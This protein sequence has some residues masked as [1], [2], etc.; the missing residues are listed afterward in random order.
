MICMQQ[1]IRK[2]IIYLT[3]SYGSFYNLFIKTAKYNGYSDNDIKSI[4]I[5]ELY[6]KIINPIKEIISVVVDLE[7]SALNNSNKFYE[8]FCFYNIS[9]KSIESSS[10]F[11]SPPYFSKKSCKTF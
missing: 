3:D 7:A 9:F 5:E 2:E 8:I 11:S 10:F 1:V 4:N 6:N